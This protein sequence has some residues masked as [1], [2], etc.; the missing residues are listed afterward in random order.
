MSSE[1][2]LMR[3]GKTEQKWMQ[4]EGKERIEYP[5]RNSQNYFINVEWKPMCHLAWAFFSPKTNIWQLTQWRGAAMV[6]EKLAKC[7]VLSEYGKMYD[8]I[9]GN[10]IKVLRN[11]IHCFFFGLR[12]DNGEWP[13]AVCSCVL[14]RQ[15]GILSPRC[16]LMNAIVY[17]WVFGWKRAMRFVCRFQLQNHKINVCSDNSLQPSVY[18]CMCVFSMVM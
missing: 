14:R 3:W 6:C 15:E 8:F 1:I 10:I 2:F 12:V 9:D 13:T 7:L 4:I 5:D 17:H 18:G 11:W 16:R